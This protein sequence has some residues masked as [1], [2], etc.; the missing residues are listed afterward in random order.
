MSLI[1]LETDELAFHYLRLHNYDCERAKF[2]LLCTIGEG[3]G[4]YVHILVT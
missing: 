1:P 4:I 3:K 2:C